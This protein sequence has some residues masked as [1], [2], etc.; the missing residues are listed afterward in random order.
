M[1]HD[2]CTLDD[3][4]TF[5]GMGMLAAVTPSLLI[6]KK[7]VIPRVK[8]TIED[9]KGIGRITLHTPRN[10]NAAVTQILYEDLVVVESENPY[11]QLNLLWMASSCRNT[12]RSSWNG[13]MQAI[14]TGDH[15]GKARIF[16][17]PMIDMP[18]TDDICITSTLYFI[19]SQAKRCEFSPIV[20]FDQRLYW[21]AMKIIHGEGPS[22]LVSNIVLKL[23]GFHII[24]SFVGCTGQLMASSGL[25]EV[26]ELVYAANTV[27]HM[28]FGKAISRAI[29]SH[30]VVQSALHPLTAVSWGPDINFL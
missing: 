19:A 3:K 9:I 24:M 6:K 22:T 7:R 26:F 10:A 8:V 23:G 20:T 28:M 14:M 17:L 21:K 5:H 18:A 29:R 11:E 27:Q 12:P 4:F 30:T 2:I 13:S 15:H 1:D 25:K 16:F